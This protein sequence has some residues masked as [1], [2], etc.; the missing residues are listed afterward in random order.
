MASHFNPLKDKKMKTTRVLLSLLAIFVVFGPALRAGERAEPPVFRIQTFEG[1][2][3]VGTI[4][5][6]TE[7]EIVFNT[8]TFGSVSIA[9]R[10]IAKKQLMSE[11]NIESVSSIPNRYFF[12]NN[13][14]GVPKG[15]GFFQ[16]TWVFFNQFSY[17][18]TDNFS[19]GAGLIPLFLFKTPTPVW[20]VPSLNIP[21]VKDNFSIGASFLFLFIAGEE[22]SLGLLTLGGTLGNR[23][24]SLTLTLGYGMADGEWAKKPLVSISGMLRTSK[25]HYILAE[26]YSL[27]IFDENINWP[28][29]GGRF[30]LGSLSLDYGLV[31]PGGDF[32]SDDIIG[33]PWL[34]ISIPMGKK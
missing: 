32:S 5:S 15:R 21:V 22:G 29:L 1:T 31:F 20:I 3:L 11:F 16:N 23:H 17:G 14:L 6:E 12:L 10:H 28:I 9:K 4:V 19:I 2:I 26:F 18:V 34:S 24:N 7:T 13:T 25:K 27:S 30:N 8:E 33:L